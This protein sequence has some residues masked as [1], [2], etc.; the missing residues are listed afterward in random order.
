MLEYTPIK[1]TLPA[2]WPY[3]LCAPFNFRTSTMAEP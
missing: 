3:V 2:L 1:D